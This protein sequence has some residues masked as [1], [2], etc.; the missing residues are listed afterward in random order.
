V[1]EDCLMNEM[2]DIEKVRPLCFCTTSSA[3]GD[4][5]SL[6]EVVA[7]KAGNGNELHA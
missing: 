4:Y 3:S 7:S 1:A 2:L 5:Y 6:G